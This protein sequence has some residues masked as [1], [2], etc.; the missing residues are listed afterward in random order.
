[1]NA[2]GFDAGREDGIFGAVTEQAV[3]QFQ[4]DAGV[5][6]DGVCG[7]A[8]RAALERL[9]GLAAGSVAAVRERDELERTPRRLAGHRVFLAAA[10]GIEALGRAVAGELTAAGATVVLDVSGSDDPTLAAAANGFAADLCL[11]LRLA[12]EPHVHR[13]AYFENRRF[14]SEGGY[15]VARRLEAELEEVLGPSKGPAGRTYG[16]LRETHMAAVVCDLVA[17]GDLEG[18]QVVVTRTAEVARAIARGVRR[19]VEEPIDA[20]G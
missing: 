15:C 20:R 14:R 5:A 3:R 7:P 6:A 16:V 13:C 19:G 18:M 10:P 1:L 9:G 4:R 12:E 17:R 11:A 2:L 8:T